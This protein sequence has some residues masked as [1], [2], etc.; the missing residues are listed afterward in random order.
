MSGFHVTIKNAVTAPVIDV[1]PKVDGTGKPKVA[2]RKIAVYDNNLAEG[3]TGVPTLASVKNAL[4]YNSLFRDNNAREGSVLRLEEDA[5]A[6]NISAQGKVESIPDNGTTYNSPYNGHGNGTPGLTTEK[7]NRIVYSIVNYDQQDPDYTGDGK[8]STVTMQTKYTMSGH[9]YR[10]TDRNM[11][12][13]LA[14]GSPHINEIAIDLSGGKKGNDFLPQNLQWFVD[15]TR[16]RDMMGNPRV[17]TLLP[18]SEIAKAHGKEAHATGMHLL[19]RGSFETWF[20]SDE[21]VRTSTGEPALSHHSPVTK[22]FA[23][24]T[25]S[26]VYI[27]EGCNLVCGTELQPGFLLLKSGASLYGDGHKVMVSYVSVEREVNPKGSVVSLPFPMDYGRPVQESDG[28][29]VTG[30]A[31]AYYKNAAGTVTDK[32]EKGGILH[33]DYDEDTEVHEYDSEERMQPDSAF[34]F[35]AT[36]GAWR[37][38]TADKTKKLANQGV[39]LVPPTDVL[40]TFKSIYDPDDD[41]VMENMLIYSFSARGKEWEDM[42]YEE[43]GEKFKTVTLGQHDDAESTNQGADF[44]SKEDMGWNCIGIPYLVSDYHPFNGA[45]GTFVA[46]KYANNAGAPSSHYNMH[47]PHTLWLYYNGTT[48]ADG[49]TA[50]DGDGGFYSVPSWENTTENSWHLAENDTPRLWMG[51]G[52]FVQTA[53]VTGSEDLTFYRP[54]YGVTSTF[55]SSGAV[56][57]KGNTR[58]YVDEDI[59]EEV[60]RLN[61]SVK[62]RTI[63]V[64][65][66][67]GGEQLG[68]YDV[69]GRCHQ[70]ATAREGRSEWSYALSQPGIYIVTVNGV[71][72]KVVVK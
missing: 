23:P 15:Y 17:L 30:I 42:M 1:D 18:T 37:E 53:S 25:G 62:N 57:K 63:Y 14:E 51:E 20:V 10:R 58:Y 66:L 11:Y 44:T 8:D 52:I 7:P 5:W 40:T 9:N 46:N 68:I 59:D 49:T 29:Y 26:V 16:D 72:R 28:T 69:P 4:V 54:V 12:F 36:D 21:V 71:G 35:S 31:R 60:V 3:V 43:E 48:T 6:V 33:L 56:R 2:M 61:I 67:Q 41:G 39:L 22:H 70:L 45:N 32:A 27:N 64:R 38:L 19:D 65:G 24:H 34:I 13:Q 55:A 50:V 47:I